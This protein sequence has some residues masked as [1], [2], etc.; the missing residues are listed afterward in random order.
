MPRRSAVGDPTS[1]FA[2]FHSP[3][4]STSPSTPWRTRRYHRSGAAGLKT[5]ALSLPPCP[6]SPA[7]SPASFSWPPAPVAL[8]RPRAGLRPSGPCAWLGTSDCVGSKELAS[9]LVTTPEGHVLINSNLEVSVPQLRASIETLGF[10]LA[11]VKVLISQAHFDHVAGRAALLTLT[12]WDGRRR[13][14][15]RVGWQGRLRLLRPS[16]P[17][18]RWTA[19]Y[20]TATL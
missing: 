9:W 10:K 16:L 2:T 13:A 4:C 3:R 6:G 15:G 1:R 18:P 17:G 5:D 11:D 12:E 14:G 19:C 7:R 8:P 20:T